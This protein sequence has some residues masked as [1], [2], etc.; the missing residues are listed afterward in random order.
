MNRLQK[1]F[2]ESFDNRSRYPKLE[3]LVPSKTYAITIN[4]DNTGLTEV[5]LLQVYNQLM[6]HIEEFKGGLK[7]FTELST[8]NQNVHYHGFIR[9]TSYKAIGQFYLNISK[10]KQWCQFEIDTIN[11]LEQWWLYIV[12]QRPYITR[13]CKINNVPSKIKY[14]KVSK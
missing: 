11:E 7:L 3:E 1:T 13:L 2:S 10:I 5:R 4:P 8:K 14:Y 6:E 12:K 9:W